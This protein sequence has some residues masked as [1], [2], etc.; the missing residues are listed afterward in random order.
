MDNIKWVRFPALCL[1]GAVS[2]AA[3]GCSYHPTYPGPPPVR[4]YASD[5][6]D[7]YYYPDVDVYFRLDSGHYY[8]RRNGTWISVDVLP[9]PFHLDRHHRVPLRLH[10]SRPYVHH[11]EHR[12]RYRHLRGHRADQ[13]RRQL[14]SRHWDRAE[15]QHNERRYRGYRER[16]EGRRH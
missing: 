15:R 16:S 8:H 13:H 1:I 5:Y 11:H 10:G 9:R 4:H 12:E 14:H 3:T 7:Y 2:L 6:H